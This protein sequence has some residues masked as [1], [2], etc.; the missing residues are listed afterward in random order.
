MS[1]YLID[2]IAATAN[3][4]L[5]T[6]SEIVDLSGA[7]DSG[8]ESVT[9]R[10]RDS[11][12]EETRPASHVFLFSAPTLRPS[13]CAT[14]AS[15]STTRLR[16]DGELEPAAGDQHP[17]CVRR[18]RRARRFGQAGGGAIAKAPTWWRKSTRRSPRAGR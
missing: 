8:V 17:R 2:R 16:Q 6:R 11:G 14:V 1:Q 3:I 10:H 4:E 18:R 12:L 7:P 15:S 13:G 9:W 5:R